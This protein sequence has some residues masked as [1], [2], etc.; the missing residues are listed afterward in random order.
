VFANGGAEAEQLLFSCWGTVE[1]IQQGKQI[2]P[3]N[4]NS[5]IAVVV[6]TARNLIIINDVEWPIY[7]DT[8]RETIVSMDPNRGSLTF[9]RI[10][11]MISV[12][13]IEP[14]G[15]NKFHGECKPAH[16]LF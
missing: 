4:E 5:S 6:D 13:F 16:K 2:N 15:L 14:T 10:T 11:G 12:H 3:I 7:G 8:S 9:N 1:L